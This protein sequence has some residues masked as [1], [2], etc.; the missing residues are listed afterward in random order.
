MAAKAAKAAEKAAAK[1]ASKMASVKIKEE[2][3]A[4]PTTN[5]KTTG[6][7]SA[8]AVAVPAVVIEKP[9]VLDSELEFEE[10]EIQVDEVEWRGRSYLVADDGTL[11]DD[12]HSAV[13]HWKDHA[14]AG[15]E[16]VWV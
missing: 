2:P 10:E 14:V 16:P 6:K 5:K 1:A 11:Y 4:P 9:A 13:G 12:T 3:D 8:K 15:S 7:K